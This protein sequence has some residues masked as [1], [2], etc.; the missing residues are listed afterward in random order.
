MNITTRW[1]TM[2]ALDTNGVFF[3]NFNTEMSPTLKLHSYRAL[4]ELLL[5]QKV[6]YF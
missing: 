4:L 3:K 1:M 2:M 6:K 5:Q